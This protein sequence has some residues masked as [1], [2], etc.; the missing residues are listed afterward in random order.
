MEDN[1]PALLG[2]PELADLLGRKKTSLILSDPILRHVGQLD[3]AR[4]A[5]DMPRV[6]IAGVVIHS[7]RGR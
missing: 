1:R 7:V 5:G 6:S 2:A 3:R 4:Q